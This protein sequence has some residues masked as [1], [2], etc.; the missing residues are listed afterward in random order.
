MKLQAN[1]IDIHYEIEGVGPLV[2][3]SHALACDLSMWDEQAAALRARY[4][5]LRYDTRGHGGTSA[6]DGPYTLEQLAEDA[7]ALVTGLSL[8]DVHWVGLSMG[9]MVGQLFAL[10]H[11][12]LLKSLV[13]CDTTSR[14]PAAAASVWQERIRAVSE[15]GMEAMVE[16][17]LQRWFTPA[18]R[19]GRADVM[20]RVAEMIRATPVAG[21][22]GC[23]HALGRFDVADR[24]AAVTLPA[25][26]LVGDQD[27]GAPPDTARQIQAAL[28]GAQFVILESA[29]H[30]SNMEQPAE[31]NRVLLKFLNAT[32]GRGGAH[33]L[34]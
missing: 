12:P 23:C 34:A 6:P 15:H 21:Y 31:F 3:L 33:A 16:P 1:G 9:G 7:H 2:V 25:L 32:T 22:V 17:T 19:M 18:F 24:L 28:P 11:Q 5:V 29:S 27:S 13:L 8:S 26:I 30:L 4:R 14:S 10:T 20:D